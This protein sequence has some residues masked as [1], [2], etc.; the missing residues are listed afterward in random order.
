MRFAFE[1]QTGDA[2]KTTFTKALTLVAV[3]LLISLSTSGGA[4]QQPDRATV[5]AREKELR[6]LEAAMMA[7]AVEKGADGYMSFYAEDAVELPDGA[8]ML[9]GKETIG[10][11]MTFLNDKNNRLTWVPVHVDVSESGDLGYTFGNYEFRSIREDGKPS[12][13]H[14]KY[15]TIWKKQKDGRW[16]VVLD[17]CNASPEPKDA[18]SQ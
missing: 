1:M 7:A 15:T 2:M 18:G 10:K 5:S 8:P 16:K 4:Q 9:L 17:M 14:G 13:E 3:A 11:T 12:V 6:A